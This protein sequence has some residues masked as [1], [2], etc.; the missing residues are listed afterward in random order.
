MLHGEIYPDLCFSQYHCFST[1]MRLLP[2]VTAARDATSDAGPSEGCG[3]GVVAH[4]IPLSRA[5]ATALNVA[6]T[7]TE[8]QARQTTDTRSISQAGVVEPSLCY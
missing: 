3:A 2:V 7:D 1:V 6:P 4:V 5:H 8:A